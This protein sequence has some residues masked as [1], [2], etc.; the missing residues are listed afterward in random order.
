MAKK[1]KKTARRPARR[2]AKKTRR[3][4]KAK[5][6]KTVRRKKSRRAKAK[7]APSFFSETHAL[8]ERLAGHNTF[9]D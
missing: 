8:R 4:A 7:G 2:G 6:A 5:K 1:R 3:A 9:E